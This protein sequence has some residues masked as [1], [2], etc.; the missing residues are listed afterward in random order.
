MRILLLVLLVLV[1]CVETRPRP[2]LTSTGDAGETSTLDV[3]PLPAPPRD[4][5]YVCACLVQVPV[6]C[7][8]H[9]GFVA[10]GTHVTEDGF[11]DLGLRN[12]SV[13]FPAASDALTFADLQADCETR[14]QAV[15]SQGARAF[16]RHCTEACAI[17]YGCSAVRYDGTVE[18]LRW[19]RCEAA[20]APIAL[21]FVPGTWEG[22]WD[23][24][25]FVPATSTPE[26]HGVAPRDSPV[27]CGRL[28]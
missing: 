5:A 22:N 3:A 14:V 21:D 18:T 11:C 24:A 23:R 17:R 13:C 20:C 9:C 26:C 10:S 19:D 27:V 2:F 15:V 25:T 6:E 1:G 4:N 12:A 8:S 7:T 16:Y 28:L